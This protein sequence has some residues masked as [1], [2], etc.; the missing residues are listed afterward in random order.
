WCL[1]NRFLVIAF[2]AAILGTGFWAIKKTP[3]D[4]IPDIGVNQQIVF[5]DWPG[6]SPKDVEDQVVY[7]LT[8]NLLG[9]PGVEVIRS[10][11]MFGFGMIS[12]IFEDKVD[13]YWS[14]T[15]VLEKLN[16]ALKDLPEGVVP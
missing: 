9:I 1:T 16:L 8:I 7:P 4:A 14:R 2:L 3:I 10:N 13:F 6:R 5:V 12:I 11:S 15:R